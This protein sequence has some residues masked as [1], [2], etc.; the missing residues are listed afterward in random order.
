MVIIACQ[1]AALVQLGTGDA[2]R[3]AMGAIAAD[4]YPPRG[5]EDADLRRRDGFR[6]RQRH[7]EVTPRSLTT[8]EHQ[9]RNNRYR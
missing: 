1:N 7:R 3:K 5:L 2:K 9:T 8:A 4:D 6:Y